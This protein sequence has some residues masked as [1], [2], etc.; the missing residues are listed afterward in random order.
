[1]STRRRVETEHAGAKNGGGF[2][3][4][5]AD[6]KRISNTLRRRADREAARSPL[7]ECVRCGHL[8]NRHWIGHSAGEA[9][10]EFCF[11]GAYLGPPAPPPPSRLERGLTLDP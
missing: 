7:G 3:G 9:A 1:M 5:R 8:S 4:P 2:Y 11:C 6:A 10:C